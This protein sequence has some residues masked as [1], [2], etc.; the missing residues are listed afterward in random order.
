M[1]GCWYKMHTA[2][3][4]G[5][6]HPTQSRFSLRLRPGVA[7]WLGLVPLLNVVA[8]ADKLRHVVVNRLQR[9]FMRVYH[10]P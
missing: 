3:A 6:L 9:R 4:A 1:D 10:V 5:F 8:A 7:Y 2:G